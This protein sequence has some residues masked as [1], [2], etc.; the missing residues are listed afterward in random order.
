MSYRALL[1]VFC[2]NRLPTTNITVVLKERAHLLYAFASKKKINICTMI[3]KN[4]SGR[5]TRR[6]AY[7]N[8]EYLLCCKDLSIPSDSWVR[9]LEPLVMPNSTAPG[10]MPPSPTPSRQGHTGPGRCTRQ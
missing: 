1:I 9:A 2:C 10:V 7:T 8:T 6:R 3:F 4:I 5:L